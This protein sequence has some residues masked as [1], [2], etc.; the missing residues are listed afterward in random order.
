M[1][2]RFLFIAATLA[3]G[4]AAFAQEA[5]PENWVNL[6]QGKDNVQGVSTERM[7]AE[8]LKGRTSETVIVAVIDSG[9]DPE[10]EDLKEIMWVNEDEIPGNGIDDDQNGYVD[11]VHGWNFIGGKGGKNINAD[12][13][14]ISRLVAHYQKKYD[15]K[16]PLKLSNKEN[17]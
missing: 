7:Y 11:D 5:A 14:E 1:K 15:G 13:L 12:A 17:K 2:L 16:D 10:H 3:F 9:V 4:T 6:D 8:L